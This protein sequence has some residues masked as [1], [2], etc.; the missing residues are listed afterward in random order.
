MYHQQQKVY[1]YLNNKVRSFY[2][3]CCEINLKVDEDVVFTE[4]ENEKIN[5]CTFT[6]EMDSLPLKKTY[7]IVKK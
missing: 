6:V 7:K 5:Q 4:I 3:C 1:L 2:N